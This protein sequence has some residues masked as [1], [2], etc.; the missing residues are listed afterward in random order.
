MKLEEV[1]LLT[2][3][4]AKNEAEKK[5]VAAIKKAEAEREKEKKKLQEIERQKRDL[6]R[7]CM[8]HIVE[9][10]KKGKST[11]EVYNGRYDDEGIKSIVNPVLKQLKEFSPTLEMRSVECDNWA[12]LMSETT[13]EERT[14]WET[15][16]YLHFKW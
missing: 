10:A 1:K 11:A 5:R 15:H 2:K 7:W 14:W 13:H 16:P 9:A 12:D 8:E 6:H 4:G 3:E